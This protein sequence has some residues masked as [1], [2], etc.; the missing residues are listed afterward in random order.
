MELSKIIF[1]IIG[2]LFFL[3]GIATTIYPNAI[4]RWLRNHSCLLNDSVELIGY[5]LGLIGV[6]I[7]IMIFWG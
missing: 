7:L 5:I 4:R 6:T 3:F 2:S 1:M